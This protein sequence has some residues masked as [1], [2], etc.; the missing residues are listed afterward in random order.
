MGKITEI[1]R[2]SEYVML[3]TGLDLGK[4]TEILRDSEYVM[5]CRGLDLG[6]ITEKLR[7]SVSEYG[8]FVHRFRFG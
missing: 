4:I 8:F 7:D 2:D 1:L 5:L 6:N 3:F